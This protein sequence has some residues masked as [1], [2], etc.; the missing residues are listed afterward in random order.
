MNIKSPSTLTELSVKNVATF[1]QTVVVVDDKA[2]LRPLAESNDG[3]STSEIVQSDEEDSAGP[4]ANLIPP[5]SDTGDYLTD[6]EDLDAKSLIDGFAEEGIACS[7]LRP[8]KEDDVV[9]QAAKI[10]EIAD[11]VVLDWILDNDNGKRVSGLIRRMIDGSSGTDRVRL[12]AIYTGERDLRQVADKAADVLSER[13][14]EPPDW[15][16][17]FVLWKGSVRVVVFGKEGTPV[18][19]DDTGLIERIVSIPELPSRLIL[20]F[21]HMMTGLLPSVAI[22]G[23]SEVRAQ[24]HKLLTMFSRSLDPAYLGHRVL[25]PNPAEAEEQLVGMFAAEL[26][27]VLEYGGVTKQAGLQSIRAWVDAMVESDALRPDYLSVT[28]KDE[29]LGLLENGVDNTKGLQLGG[30]KWEKSTYAF[31]SDDYQADEA[32]RQFA[33]MM[34]VKTQYGGPPP[35]LTLGTI[36]CAE[37]TY[38]ICLQP[39]CDSVRLDGPTAFPM[40]PMARVPDQKKDIEIVVLHGDSWVL[41]SVPRR[42]A[43]LRMVAFESNDSSM[44]QVTASL[45]DD[46]MWTINPIEGPSFE[47]V[48]QLKDEHA[49]R[50]A[51]EFA[52]SFS[53]VGVSE[54]EWVRRSGTKR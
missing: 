3:S 5:P 39:K 54:S 9:S 41:L 27:S 35:S 23:L 16:S 13:F 24:S 7:V 17:D 6:P 28:S 45:N 30:W 10:A 42:P 32:N 51:N 53:R 20:E 8:A 4:Q 21:A 40:V 18:P 29:L 38:W 15:I 25:L 12:I 48:A 1:L 33:K 47:W 46:S 19:P 34:H 49:Q 14:G 11:I 50:I 52:G 26:L 37:A 44:K 31:S 22:A 43:D 2:H 36:V